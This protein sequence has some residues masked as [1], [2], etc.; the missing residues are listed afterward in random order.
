M[1]HGVHKPKTNT[2]TQ[3]S[4]DD[5]VLPLLLSLLY[6]Y[7]RIEKNIITSAFYWVMDEVR[8]VVEC[9]VVVYSWMP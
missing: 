9:S 2:K 8:G 5:D 3:N 4:E 6:F 1:G 7:K